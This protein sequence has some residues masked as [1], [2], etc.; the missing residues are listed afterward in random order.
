MCLPRSWAGTH[1]L[2]NGAQVALAEASDG[3]LCIAAKLGRETQPTVSILGPGPFLFRE[4]VGRYLLGFD[5]IRDEAKERLDFDVR[6]AVKQTVGSLMGLEIVEETSSQMVLQFL[7]A[8]SGFPPETLLARNLAIASGM[9][10]DAVDSFV[11]DDLQLAKSV[12]ARNGESERQHFFLARILNTIAQDH[13]LAEK[14]SLSLVACLSYSLAAG[15][16]QDLGNASTR[17]ATE[18]LKLNG[19]KL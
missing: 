10:R 16:V 19:V 8:P 12:V 5:A 9:S 17:V 1:G 11:A 3:R 2:R 15:V 4:I 14:L 18:T 7:L 6:A 13:G